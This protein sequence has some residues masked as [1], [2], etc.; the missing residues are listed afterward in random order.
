MQVLQQYN[1]LCCL[2]LKNNQQTTQVVEQFNTD[3]EELIIISLAGSLY[4]TVRE[5]RA[6]LGQV[7]SLLRYMAMSGILIAVDVL[8]FWVFD[9]VHHQ[10]QGEIV[11]KGMQ[12]DDSH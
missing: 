2:T 9:L 8:V 5:R 10:A 12:L 4:L 11:T 1:N 3:L 7:L 6:M